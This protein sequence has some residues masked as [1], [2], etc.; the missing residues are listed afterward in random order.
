MFLDMW[1]GIKKE[2]EYIRCPTLVPSDTSDEGD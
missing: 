2:R 1:M